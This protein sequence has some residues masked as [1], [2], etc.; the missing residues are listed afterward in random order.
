[1]RNV[2]KI[3]ADASTEWRTFMQLPAALLYDLLR[4]RQA[5]FVVEQRCAYL[6]LDGLDEPA[7]HLLLRCGGELA[8]CL[9]V[10]PSPAEI[11]IGRVAVKG[12]L[13]G[14][15]LG[16]RLMT[17][18]L[19]FCREQHPALPIVL[20]AQHHL[21]CFY[22]SFG[23]STVGEPFDDFGLTH[24]AMRNDRRRPS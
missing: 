11:R 9:R 1:M 22:E 6:D 23:F 10:V 14:R 4:L 17:E 8:G 12:E 7:S 3:E 13:R 21:I 15:G 16:R 20:T 5:I 24:V 18:A 19:G 2:A